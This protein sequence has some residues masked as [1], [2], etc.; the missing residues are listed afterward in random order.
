[1]RA[2]LMYILMIAQSNRVMVN[3]SFEISLNFDSRRDQGFFFW[4]V[5][6]GLSY[7]AECHR[8]GFSL[9][10]AASISVLCA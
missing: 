2:S 6:R 5:G 9:S 8:H 3:N 7:L 1:M 4:T 10:Y